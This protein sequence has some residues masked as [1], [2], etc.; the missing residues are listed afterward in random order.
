MDDLTGKLVYPIV[1]GLGILFIIYPV[2]GIANLEEN[3]VKWVIG[4]LGFCVIIWAG[5]GII[6]D[7]ASFRVHLPPIHR[8]GVVAL[9]HFLAG[10]CTGIF[11]SLAATGY[12]KIRKRKTGVAP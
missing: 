9:H 2:S 4:F 6:M 12:L 10:L 8:Q 7:T 1:I 5:T 11:I 3:R